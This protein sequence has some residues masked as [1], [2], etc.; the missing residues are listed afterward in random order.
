MDLRNKVWASKGKQVVVAGK[1]V[2]IIFE[3]FAPKICLIQLRILNH[4]AHRAIEDENAFIQCLCKRFL[5]LHYLHDFNH[6]KGDL[7]KNRAF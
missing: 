4:G 1:I 6:Q 3:A 7:A 2:W 5:R